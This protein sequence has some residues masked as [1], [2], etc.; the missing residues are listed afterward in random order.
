MP[1]PTVPSLPEAS[2]GEKYVLLSAF[3]WL[4]G[5]RKLVMLV[6]VAILAMQISPNF[7]LNP[8]GVSYMSIAR[9][10]ALHGRLERLGSAHA[11]F[12]P[13]YAVLISPAFFFAARPFVLIQ[14]INLLLCVLFML[15]T[16]AWLARYDR[17]MALLATAFVL[18]NAGFMDLF[19]RASAEM[20]FM[21]A[22][23]GAALAL[24][25][26][27]Q[28]RQRQTLWKAMAAAV[29]LVMLAC[30]I[31][32]V[33]VIL[34]A[35]FAAAMVAG[36]I[37]GQ[38]GWLRAIVCTSA[39]AAAAG[40]V[41][42]ALVVHD[43]Q[44]AKA[45]S[46]LETGYT[47]L[48]ETTRSLNSRDAGLMEGL[49]RE[50]AE[51]GRLVLPGLWKAHAR[52]GQWLNINTILY[53]LVCIPVAVG[54]WRFARKTFDPLV[55]TFPFYF[56]FL[57]CFPFDSGARYMVPMLPVVSAGVWL[58]LQSLRGRGGKE[59]FFVLV[60]VHLL[61]SIGFWQNSAMAARR[62]ARRWP[63][64]ERVATMI[65]RDQ[66]A[67]A[68]RGLDYDQSLFLE[69]VVDRRI[70]RLEKEE[71]IH[72]KVEWLLAPQSSSDEPGFHLERAM[73]GVKLERRSS[74]SPE[75]TTRP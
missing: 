48:N 10:L 69:Y 9:N 25:V 36:A 21:P 50:T 47:Y 45:G 54:W 23:M 4:Q 31:R 5:H 58:A 34:A 72:P 61:V 16:Y 12:A 43:N 71:T 51:V 55:L 11:H 59:V 19:R 30:F 42:A 44:A 62:D 15:G 22:M 33:G 13:G 24:A 39:M 1:Q 67:L 26:A 32:Q 14:V 18:V 74:V 75:A 52:S 70:F 29:M 65:P 17:E 46:E 73:E 6:L 38:V 56:V 68:E 20:A 2:T 35:G 8:D 66:G 37:R 64:T 3:E 53:L 40:L 28:T 63:A 60:V 41:C 57:V 7:E 49:R 27:A